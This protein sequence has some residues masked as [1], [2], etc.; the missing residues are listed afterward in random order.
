MKSNKTSRDSVHVVL[1]DSRSMSPDFNG[2]NRSL[3]DSGLNFTLLGS[4]KIAAVTARQKSTSRPVQL[5]LS[6]GLEN[7]GSPWLTPQ[8]REPRSF[9]F[10][11]VCAEAAPAQMPSSKAKPTMLVTRF[12]GRPFRNMLFPWCYGSRIFLDFSASEARL[13]EL[14]HHAP[15]Y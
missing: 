8:M 1:R 13:A 5:P 10:L 11:S 15:A 6:S 3:A 12:M 9:T 7:P 2:S 14:G 4:L